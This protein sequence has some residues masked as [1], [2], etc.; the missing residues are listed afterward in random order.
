MFYF[1]LC[2]VRLS[3]TAQL[4]GQFSSPSCFIL[5]RMI[6]EIKNVEHAQ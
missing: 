3:E 4:T 6:L 5:L 1:T 2:G